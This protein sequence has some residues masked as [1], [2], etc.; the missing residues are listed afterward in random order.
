MN[1]KL[2]QTPKQSFAKPE[3][4]GDSSGL[5]ADIV[6]Q[7]SRRLQVLA[8]IYATVYVI[9]GYLIPD[10]EAGIVERTLTD[11]VIDV[12]GLLFILSALAFYGALR[13]GWAGTRATRNVAI[14]FEVVG[15]V[16]IE[17]WIL[18]WDGDLSLI[19]LG[20]SWTAVWI[21]SFPLFAPT[22]PWT[23][24]WTATVAASARPLMLAIVAMRGTPMPDAATLI[25][26]TLP[27]YLC[28]GIATMAAQV[29][30]GLGKDIAKARRMGNYSLTEKLGAGGMGEV[31]KAEHRMLARP[32]AIKLVRSDVEGDS[33]LMYPERFEREV[34][35]TAQLQSPHTIE[36]YDYGI[37]ESGSFYYV[38]ELLDGLDLENLVRFDGPLSVERTVHIL[39]QTCHSLNE[40]HRKGMVH[41]DIKPANI[42][43][44][45]YAGDVDFVKVLDFGL[46]KRGASMDENEVMLTKVGTFTGTPAYASPE[47]ASGNTDQVDAGSDIYSLGCVGFWLLTGRTVF[48]ASNTL[49]MLIK[50][51]SEPPVAPS[52]Y[53]EFDVPAELDKIILACLEKGRS[54]RIESAASLSARLG[55]IEQSFPWDADDAR[56]WWDMRRPSESE[57]STPMPRHAEVVKSTEL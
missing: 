7:A 25:A 21:V 41:R 15:A 9:T 37:T 30:F 6:D 54:K 23:T 31:W 24:F 17:I 12:F 57:R 13:Y 2:V 10:P 38:M 22:R 42:F 45:R 18:G 32:A 3:H 1:Q 53:S 27:T 43:L 16:G 49:E 26:L 47:M 28:V 4:A 11:T 35:A 14:A 40:A 55:A 39:R 48:E 52:E 36:V 56:K 20:L 19:Q 33:S 5:P 50:Q 51:G 8:L 29:L 34:Q 46:V 44:C